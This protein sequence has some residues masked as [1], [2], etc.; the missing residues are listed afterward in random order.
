M[1][2]P[3]E[4]R[5]WRVIRSVI[6]ER[7]HASAVVYMSGYADAH[8]HH[9]ALKPGIALLRKPFT[10]ETVEGKAREILYKSGTIES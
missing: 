9:G 4:V 8:V 3:V 5:Q 7:A 10:A 6:R 1:P 2:V